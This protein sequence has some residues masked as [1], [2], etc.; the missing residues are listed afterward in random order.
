MARME[1]LDPSIRL[2]LELSEDPSK[3]DINSGNRAEPSMRGMCGQV[4]GGNLSRKTGGHIREAQQRGEAGAL[5]DRQNSVARQ[6]GSKT[7]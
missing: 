3:G 6:R 5:A 7:M 2:E 4:G 1:K